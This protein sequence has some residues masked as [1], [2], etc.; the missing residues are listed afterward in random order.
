LQVYQIAF[1]GGIILANLVDR[2]PFGHLCLK[3]LPRSLRNRPEPFAHQLINQG[4]F[5]TAGSAR[6]HVPVRLNPERRPIICQDPNLM[7]GTGDL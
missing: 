5:A 6:Y 4:C 2:S 7:L 3:V 1:Q